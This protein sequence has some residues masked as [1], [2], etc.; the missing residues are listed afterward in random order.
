[1]IDV[2]AYQAQL[3]NLMLPSIKDMGNNIEQNVHIEASFPE[4]KDRYEI[5]EAFNNLIN[6][7]NDDRLSP[8]EQDKIKEIVDMGVQ[9]GIYQQKSNLA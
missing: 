1:M 2:Q 8:D 7:S 6:L 4:A 5:E 9:V 3:S